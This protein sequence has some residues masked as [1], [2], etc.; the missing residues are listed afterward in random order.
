MCL[1]RES[2]HSP[3]LLCF[4]LHSTAGFEHVNILGEIKLEGE[5]WQCP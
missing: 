1:Q 4:G 3:H 2:L 5:L